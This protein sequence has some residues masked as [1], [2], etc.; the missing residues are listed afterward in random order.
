[1]QAVSSPA[2]MTGKRLDAGV[3]SQM[4]A[5]SDYVPAGSGPAGSGLVPGR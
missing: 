2:N 4:A 1:M 3:C 5:S